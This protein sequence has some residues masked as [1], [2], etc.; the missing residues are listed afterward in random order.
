M[1]DGDV[2]KC[3]LGSVDLFPLGQP[4]VAKTPR[5]KVIV[6]RETANH[7]HVWL[8]ICPHMG[9][10]FQQCD[11]SAETVECSMHQWK[12]NLCTGKNIDAN[13]STPLTPID[14]HIVDGQLIVHI[15]A[16]FE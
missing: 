12:F 9:N 14:H 10:H 3:N 6:Y 13:Y 2:L 16:E 7:F 11:C 4:R 8:G 5:G 15:P 1:S